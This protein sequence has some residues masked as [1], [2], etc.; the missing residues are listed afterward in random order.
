MGSKQHYTGAQYLSRHPD[1]KA[2]GVDPLWHWLTY[3][4]GEGRDNAFPSGWTPEGYLAA[5]PDIAA[6]PVWSLQ[7]EEHWLIDGVINGRPYHIDADGGADP[8]GWQPPTQSGEVCRLP[9]PFAMSGLRTPAGL[10]IGTYRPAKLYRYDGQFRELWAGPVESVYMIQRRQNGRAMFATE[11]PAGIATEGED[12]KFTWTQL[13]PEPD[14]LAFDIWP[15]R[16]GWILF[17]TNNITRQ[18]IRTY[19]SSDD[20]ATWKSYKDHNAVNGELFQMCTDGQTYWVSGHRDRKPYMEDERGKQVFW[21]SDYQE[22]TINYA[23]VKDGLFTLGLHNIDE[24]IQH[25]GKR[26]NGYVLWGLENGSH[27][28]GIDLMP[29]YIMQTDI[30]PQTAERFAVASIWNESGYPNPQVAR[31]KDGKTW[32]ESDVVTIPFPSVQTFDW[33]DEGYYC[34]GG[35]Y[36]EFLAVYYHR[37]T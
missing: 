8:S 13:R 18:N 4:A 17:T 24:I 28:L 30:H 19:T 29:P 35:K 20:G 37:L 2:A 9:G 31:S 21:M 16:G 22:Q 25:D 3:G 5:N 36:G 26:R 23:S 33:G 1:V 15:Y 34:F 32:K 11:H 6:D 10:L 27:P 7:P 12:G 14:S